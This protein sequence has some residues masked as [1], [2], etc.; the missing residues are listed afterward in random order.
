MSTMQVLVVQ[1]LNK[2]DASWKHQLPQKLK[3]LNHVVVSVEDL[4]SIRASF[5]KYIDKV[6]QFVMDR[7]R[8]DEE[9]VM[10]G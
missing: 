10:Q 9:E 6:L 5:D 8:A 4:V 7:Q 2:P 1:S 3:H